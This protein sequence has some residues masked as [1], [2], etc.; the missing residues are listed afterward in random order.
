MAPRTCQKMIVIA[1]V[2]FFGLIVRPALGRALEPD[3]VMVIATTRAYDSYNLVV[4]LP[5]LSWHMGLIGES[6]IN[7]LPCCITEVVDRMPLLHQHSGTV[8]CSLQNNT[9]W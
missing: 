1:A 7:Y 4:S 9:V 8:I 5:Y 2:V 3:E 6:S